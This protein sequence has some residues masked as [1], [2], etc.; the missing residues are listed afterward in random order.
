MAKTLANIIR[1]YNI[2][3]FWEITV[4]ESVKLLVRILTRSLY[5]VTSVHML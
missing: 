4:T 5:I 3:F 1:H 2:S